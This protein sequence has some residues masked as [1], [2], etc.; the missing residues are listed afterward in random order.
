[1]LTKDSEWTKF[2]KTDDELF[3]AVVKLMNEPTSESE[4]QIDKNGNGR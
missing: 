3:N 4:A 2:S 1:M